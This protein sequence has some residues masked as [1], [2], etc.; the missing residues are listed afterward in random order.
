M[1]NKINIQIIYVIMCLL[2]I[3]IYIYLFITNSIYSIRETGKNKIKKSLR[4]TNQ[5]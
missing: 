3:Y 2:N 4:Y 5:N 1:Q